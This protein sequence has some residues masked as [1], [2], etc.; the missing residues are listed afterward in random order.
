[1]MDMFDEKM[2]ESGLGVRFWGLGF[3]KRDISALG[4]NFEA[5]VHCCIKAEEID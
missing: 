1:M 3:G 5:Q 4:L 2:G